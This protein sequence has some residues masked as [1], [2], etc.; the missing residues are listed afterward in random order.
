VKLNPKQPV[1]ITM[2]HHYGGQMQSVM[3]KLIDE[4]NTTIGRKKGVIVSVTSISATRDIQNKLL[5]IAADE[6]G[7]PEMPDLVT[8]YPKIALILANE[9]L[10]AAFDEHFTEQ[11]L[12]AYLPQFIE[13]GRL[14]DGKLYVFPIAK[15]TEVLFVNETLF[16]RFAAATGVSLD[17][18][19]TFE[20]I[21]E[22]SVKYY[23]WTDSLTPDIPNDGKSFYTAD[24]WFNIAQVGLAQLGSVFVYEEHLNVRST[25]FR[26]IWDFTVDPVLSGGYAVTD[27]YSSELSKTGEIICSTGSTAG[28]LFYGDSITY[29]DNTIEP[30]TYTIL[31]YPVF[32]GGKKVA[33]QRGAGMC[34]GR[35]TPQK[36]YAASLFLKWFTQ[37]EQNIRFVS[38]TGYLPV[39]KEAFDN[40][41]KNEIITAKTLP[42]KR[43]L[44]AATRMYNE[45]TFLI[46]PNYEQFDDLSKAYEQN[47][48]RTMGEGRA[49][50]LGGKQTVPQISAALY[51]SFISQ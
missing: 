47:L 21:A 11:E 50:V 44:E 40:N 35:S 14:T 43:L 31:P 42:L 32:T 27:S 9:G 5:M 28:I 12:D 6:P 3:D 17:C 36:E 20:G 19:A 22:A 7:A 37:P 1:T 23:Q 30:T 48:K 13:E 34:I 49:R 26:R 18:L 4:F 25:D 38:S 10:L 39:T 16:N 51:R 15:S 24:S 46:P 45:Y 33:V 2:W 29:P 41:M 8:A